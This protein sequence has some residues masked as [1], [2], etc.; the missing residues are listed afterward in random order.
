MAA[1]FTLA[2]NHL[3]GQIMNIIDVDSQ[4]RKDFKCVQCGNAV[5]CV[6]DVPAQ[7]KHFRHKNDNH[8]S[9]GLET[10]L[11]KTAKEIIE[12]ANVIYLDST[13]KQ[14][15]HY[16]RAVTEQT[17]AHLRPDLTLYSATGN[18][19]VEIEV[20]NPVTE[21]KFLQFNYLGADCLVIDLTNY[22]RFF[23]VEDL[24]Q[25]ILFSTDDKTYHVNTRPP[26]LTT[27]KSADEDQ[28]TIAGLLLAAGILALGLLGY[29]RWQR[30]YQRQ[31]R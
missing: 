14:P 6:L 29:K 18:L 4:T 20:S 2:R 3:T 31:K 13:Q 28:K 23:H 11:H 26:Y 21:E 5:V 12:K 24:K 17:L 16:E 8:C 19:Y 30:N 7:T 25:K 9:P 10:L 22:D 27:E 15:F 1:K